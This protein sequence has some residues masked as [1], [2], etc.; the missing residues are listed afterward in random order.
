MAKK[1]HVEKKDSGTEFHFLNSSIT[2]PDSPGLFA[3]DIACG[4]G[5][6]TAL[7]KFVALNWEEGVCIAVPTIKDA[8]DMETA[9]VT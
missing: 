3:F 9:L 5:K 4:S 6:S 8:N 1:I 7:K 2:L